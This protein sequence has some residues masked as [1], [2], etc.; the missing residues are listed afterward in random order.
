M[1]FYSQH[2]LDNF[3][4]PFYDRRIENIRN[5]N[6]QSKV[7]LDLS[8]VTFWLSVIDFYGGLYYIGKHNEIEPLYKRKKKTTDLTLLKLAHSKAFAEFVADF[9][10]KSKMEN[11][12][13]PLL[14]SSFRS[15]IVHQLSPKKGVLTWGGRDQ[16]LLWVEVDNNN[17]NPITNKTVSININRF[18][19]LSYNSYKD[20][21]QKIESGEHADIC[22]NIYDHLISKDDGLQDGYAVQYE[23]SQLKPEVKQMITMVK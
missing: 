12:L 16:D 15:G 9:F 1:D 18:E 8:V 19:E 20:F 4:Q 23:Y 17:S 5:M 3:F 7:D 13:G 6:F 10:P 11:E 2:V 21:K 22:K 14:Y